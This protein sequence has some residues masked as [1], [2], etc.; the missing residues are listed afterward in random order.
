MKPFLIAAATA[1]MLASPTWGEEAPSPQPSKGSLRVQDLPKP[2][3]ELLDKI[4]QLSRKIEP[5]ISRMGSTLG[6]E[7]KVTVKKLCDE[8]QCQD[9]PESK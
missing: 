2:I 8:L 3:P 4:Q 9:R 6:Q 7:L 5:E 1:V